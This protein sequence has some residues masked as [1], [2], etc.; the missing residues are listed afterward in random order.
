MDVI[1]DNV[2]N[3]ASFIP[4]HMIDA[5]LACTRYQNRHNW[6]WHRLIDCIHMYCVPI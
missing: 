6:N 5:K 3:A 4:Q 2:G 1:T